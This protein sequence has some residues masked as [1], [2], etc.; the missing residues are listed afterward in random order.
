L[1]ETDVFVIGGGPAGLAAAIAARQRNLRVIVADG[2][3]PPVDK[4]CGEGLLPDARAA[5]ERLGLSIPESIGFEFRGVRFHAGERRVEADFPRGCGIGVRRTALHQWLI[6][7]AERAGA[8]L[9]WATPVSRISEISAR[10]IVGSDGAAS[11]VRTQAGLEATL[12]NSRRFASRRHFAVEPWTDCMEIYWGPG[13]QIYVTPVARNEVCLSLIS[14]QPTLRLSEAIDRSFPALRQR[15]DG[16]AP[17]SRERGTVTATRRLRRVTSGNVALI[18]DASGSVDAIT[19][20]GICLAFKQAALLAG[21]MADGDLALYNRA[22]PCLSRRPRWMAKTMLLLDRGA[23]A[24]S[25]GFAALQMQ[26]WM[27]RKLLAV[28]VGGAYQI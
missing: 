4:P 23:A 9:R 17:T 13:C 12:W 7:M 14:R 11:R 22:H 21:A 10:W 26:P 16:A 27:F 19:G 15:L 18:G 25:L 6:G 3:T 5:A 2:N 28:H 8:D 24:R 1:F 20:E